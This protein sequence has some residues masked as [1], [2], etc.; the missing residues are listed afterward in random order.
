LELC[1]ELL[2]VLLSFAKDYFYELVGLNDYNVMKNIAYG[3]QSSAQRM[4]VYRPKAQENLYPC[5]VLVHGGAF[6]FGDKFMESFH[7]R[8]LVQ[9]GYVAVTI[10][11]RLS[12]EAIFPAAILDCRA[13]V[14]YL[15][16]HAKKFCIDTKQIGAW[17][18]SAGGNLVSMLGTSSEHQF[19]SEEDNS[20]PSCQVQ[21]VVNWFGPIDFCKIDDEARAL[22]IKACTDQADSFESLYMGFPVQSNTQQTSQANPTTYINDN[23]IP[24]FLIMHGDQDNLIPYTQSKHFADKLLASS[25]TPQVIL[26]LIKGAGHGGFLFDSHQNLAKVLDFFDSHLKK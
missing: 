5:V 7:A 13:A 19:S 6:K 15:R 1:E 17:G 2:M 24:P 3:E 8:Y 18:S 11:Y 16:K 23:K 25:D 12:G 26:E 9:R 4:D 20:G 22:G 10:N 21:A 14:R